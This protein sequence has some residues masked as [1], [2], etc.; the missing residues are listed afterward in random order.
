MQFT[1]NSSGSK[2]SNFIKLLVKLVFIFLIIF[3]LVFLVDKI[4]FPIPKK[5]IEKIIP[6][7][8]FKIVK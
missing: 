2:S 5:N 1:R 6:N 7:E 3:L 8:K 4:E